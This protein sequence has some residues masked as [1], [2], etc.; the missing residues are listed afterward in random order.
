MGSLV[1]GWDANHIDVPRGMG[2]DRDDDESNKEPQG[3]F[4]R[5]K[6]HRIGTGAGGAAPLDV[7]APSL[8]RTSLSRASAS[9]TMKSASMPRTGA[10]GADSQH[11]Y[12]FTDWS[13]ELTTLKG[14]EK[15]VPPK[16]VQGD[17]HGHEVGSLDRRSADWW[18]ALEVGHLNE[19]PTEDP[20]DNRK[21]HA[22]SSF[23]P[24]MPL[25]R[26]LEEAE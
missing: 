3:Y 5:L 7:P 11:K 15:H 25:L 17:Q 6:S 21:L 24:Q 18:R 22:A 20:D 10:H 14:K 16:D 12:K 2:P 8:G 26:K 1:P 4:S 23:V 9:A 19:H 13:E